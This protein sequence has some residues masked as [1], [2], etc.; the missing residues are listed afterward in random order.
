MKTTE[1][2]L[3]ARTIFIATVNN[4]HIPYKHVVN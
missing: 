3:L 2:L 1:A 4:G